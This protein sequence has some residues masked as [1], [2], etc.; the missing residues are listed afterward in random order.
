MDG[1]GNVP[2]IHIEPKRRSN[3]CRCCDDAVRNVI[4]HHGV[5]VEDKND[6]TESANTIQSGL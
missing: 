3:V 1:S 5:A 2:V 4:A 6:H